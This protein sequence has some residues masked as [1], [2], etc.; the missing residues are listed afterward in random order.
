ME[1]GEENRKHDESFALTLAFLR[2]RNARRVEV[3]E[4]A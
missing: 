3:D 2:R 1:R 4:P